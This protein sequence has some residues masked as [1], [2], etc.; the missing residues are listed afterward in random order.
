[1][2]LIQTQNGSDQKIEN[3][4]KRIRCTDSA[5]K[6][7]I[8]WCSQELFLLLPCVLVTNAYCILDIIFPHCVITQCKLYTYVIT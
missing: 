7:S 8:N 2:K 1:M 6:A 5:V 4:Q 3:N